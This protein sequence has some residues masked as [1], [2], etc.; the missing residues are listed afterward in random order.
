MVQD[1]RTKYLIAQSSCITHA[2]LHEVKLVQMQTAN[3]LLHRTP[4][5]EAALKLPVVQQRAIVNVNV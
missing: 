3:S 2:V 4:A 5:R 1:T